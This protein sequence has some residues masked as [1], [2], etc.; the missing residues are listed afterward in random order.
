MSK[1]DM[2]VFN[3]VFEL[4]G[5]DMSSML[6]NMCEGN[7]S[8]KLDTFKEYPPYPSYQLR[9]T[10]PDLHAEQFT[11]FTE[12]REYNNKLHEEYL[13]SIG[14]KHLEQEGGGEG[15]AEDCH[16]V[17][18]FKG[19]IYRGCYSYYSYN[20]HEYDYIESTLQEVKPVEK[21]IIVYEAI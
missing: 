12:V 20:G 6:Y 3:D 1:V 7:F 5:G 13:E 11:A 9:E 19:K 2:C 21:T 8:V 14:Y 10:D 15:G 18:S 16:G 4:Y 17:F